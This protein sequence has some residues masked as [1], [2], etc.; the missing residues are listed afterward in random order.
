MVKPLQR[1]LTLIELI[2][3]IVVIGVGLVGILA[4]YNTVV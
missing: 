3:F 2:I 1:G 4:A